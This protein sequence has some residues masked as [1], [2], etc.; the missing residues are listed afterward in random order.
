M[1]LRL[2]TYFIF[3]ILSFNSYAQ[4]S[5][6]DNNIYLSGNKI[7]SPLHPNIVG[8]NLFA[9]E[10]MVVISN[11][12][13]ASSTTKTEVNY[14]FNSLTEKLQ[15]VE[16]INYSTAYDRYY[17]YVINFSN[18]EKILNID[19]DYIDRLESEFGF[20]D[21]SF[22]KKKEKLILMIDFLDGKLNF[23]TYDNKSAV[24]VNYN[25]D[26]NGGIN[27][28]YEVCEFTDLRTS[29]MA[30]KQI[31]FVNSKSILYSKSD[32]KYKSKMYLVKDD[33]VAILNEQADKQGQKWYFINYKGKKDVNMWIKAEDVDLKEK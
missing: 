31:G 7:D 27:N 26:Y 3:T 24:I 16:W 29:S 4:I 5:I 32:V 11:S 28:R 12:Y 15:R 14:F 22:K 18:G 8:S 33:Q 23:E 2:T 30:C 19:D 20:K 13:T 6:I 9:Y 25:I 21:Y 10:D 17:G 1:A